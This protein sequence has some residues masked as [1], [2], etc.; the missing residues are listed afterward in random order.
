MT[1]QTGTALLAGRSAVVTGA[2]PGR[3]GD[4]ACLAKGRGAGSAS[5]GVD[6]PL[7]AS[8]AP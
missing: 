2:A 1:Q 4:G 6:G 3:R 5:P 8:R 7:E